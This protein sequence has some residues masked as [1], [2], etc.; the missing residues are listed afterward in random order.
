MPKLGLWLFLFSVFS[1]ANAADTATIAVASNFLKPAKALQAAF[2]N[3]TRHRLKVVS[4]SSG[5][6]YA[7]ITHGAPFD[8]F[9]SADQ[10]IP[11]QLV[12]DDLAL[13][14]NVITY[15]RGSLLLWSRERNINQ[16]TLK[17]KLLNQDFRRLAVAN[18]EIA[19]YGKAAMQ[20]LSRLTIDLKSGLVLGENI[21]QTY[22]FIETGNAEIGFIAASQVTGSEN[23][24]SSWIVDSKLYDPILQDAVI[25]NTGTKNPVALAFMA[26]LQSDD[27]I[28]II[29][30]F[31][32][33]V[34]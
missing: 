31:N 19:P 30:S 13:A 21:N 27:A 14:D 8:I 11:A 7:Q 16:E 9:L 33:E 1:A 32:Y 18:P 20:V 29:K 4:A 26:F 12:S 2:E 3:S 34:L 22:Q 23:S 28:K 6:L 17:Q 24:G 15:A 10:V 25:L 5:K